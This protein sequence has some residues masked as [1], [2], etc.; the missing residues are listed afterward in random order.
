MRA[1]DLGGLVT[2]DMLATTVPAR[3]DAVPIQQKNRVVGQVLDEIA[4]DILPGWSRL[5]H[6]GDGY[7]G[8]AEGP[9]IVA[10]RRRSGCPLSSYASSRGTLVAM[11]TC[12]TC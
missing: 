11:T 5:W 10:P 6:V 7:G 3:H 4:K 8:R 12:S 9:L 1:D 2:D